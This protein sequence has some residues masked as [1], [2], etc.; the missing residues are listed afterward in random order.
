MI[1]MES[2]LDVGALREE[3]LALVFACRPIWCMSELPSGKAIFC[4]ILRTVNHSHG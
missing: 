4:A 1:L 2:K 3:L